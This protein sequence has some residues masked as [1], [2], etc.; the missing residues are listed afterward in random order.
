MENA[1]FR[2]SVIRILLSA[3][4]HF[5]NNLKELICRWVENIARQRPKSVQ[6]GKGT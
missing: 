4:N 1:R 3:G 5:T 2:K 6:Q